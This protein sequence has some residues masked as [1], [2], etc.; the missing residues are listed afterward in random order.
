MATSVPAHITGPGTL[1]VG[2]TGSLSDLAVACT[3]AILTPSVESE[4]DVPV[5]SGDIIAGA[6]TFTWELQAT[7]FQSFDAEGITDFLFKHRGEVLPFTYRPSNSHNQTWKGKLKIR[8]MDVGGDVKKRNT[9]DVALPLVGEPDLT[10]TTTTKP[11][12]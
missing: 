3:K 10:Y 2:E 12:A 7:L 4:D 6:D 1:T 5:L 11:G 9:S 8:P